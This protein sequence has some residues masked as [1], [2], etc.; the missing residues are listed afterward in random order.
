MK[1]CSISAAM[2]FTGSDVIAATQRGYARSYGIQWAPCR[3]HR[4][5][6]AHKRGNSAFNRT[7]KAIKIIILAA[8]CVGPSLREIVLAFSIRVIKHRTCRLG[9]DELSTP[10][11]AEH[12]LS[13]SMPCASDGRSSGPKSGSQTSATDGSESDESL[14][15]NN[16]DEFEDDDE[17]EKVEGPPPEPST[18]GGAGDS[19]PE[20]P[21]IGAG[22]SD[23]KRPLSH[24]QGHTRAAGKKL[25]SGAVIGKAELT[26]DIG[27]A[28]ELQ[29]WLYGLQ[30]ESF[31]RLGLPGRCL[32][33]GAS[34]AKVAAGVWANEAA[35]VKVYEFWDTSLAAAGFKRE[36]TALLRLQ[37]V[38]G[39]IDMLHHGTMAETDAAV[40]E[41]A[42]EYSEVERLIRVG[43]D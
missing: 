23:R 32:G 43:A 1:A 16:G 40:P 9:T 18:G 26:G 14:D 28:D 3:A 31:Q 30:S 8:D 22:P 39:C 11:A 17:E 35:A 34:G 21:S 25:R 12:L 24:S 33:A 5:R 4:E 41:M 38:H 6:R 37:G 20:D 36:V 42:H 19:F 29:Q 27:G 7:T 10:K 2:W 15:D 13:D